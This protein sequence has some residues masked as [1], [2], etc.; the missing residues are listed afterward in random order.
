MW[1]NHYTN[2]TYMVLGA[3]HDSDKENIEQTAR[4][5]R[6][7]TADGDEADADAPTA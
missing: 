1:V 6:Q 7:R 5:K 3:A 2:S 4:R